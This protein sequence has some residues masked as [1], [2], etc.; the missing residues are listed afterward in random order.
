MISLHPL[1]LTARRLARHG[2]GAM[3]AVATLCL[4]GA[5]PMTGPRGVAAEPAPGDTLPLPVIALPEVVVTDSYERALATVRSATEGTVTRRQIE[6]RPLRRAG[7]LLESVPGFVVSQHS[8]EGKAN[9][10]YLRGFNLDH[11]TDV[12]ITLAGVPVNMPSHGHG[13]GYADLSYAIP[14][15]IAGIDYR[16]GTYTAADGDFSAAGAVQINYLNRL[17]RPIVRVTGGELG[18]GRLLAAASLDPARDQ[19]LLAAFDLFRNDGPWERPDDF[20]KGVGL[21][22]Y[23][24]GNAAAGFS[25]TAMGYDGRWNSTDQIPRRAVA[26]G[27]LDRY[28]AVDDTDGGRSHR[29]SLSGEYRNVTPAGITRSSAFLIHY[30]MRLWSNF[31]YFLGDPVNGDQFEQ[32]DDR[33]V[34]GG[35]VSRMRVGRMLARPVHHT[36]GLQVR[37][38]NIHGVGL[39]RT[40]ARERLATVRQ[41]DVRQTSVSPFAQSEIRWGETFRTVT[42]L[43]YDRYW[44]NVDSHLPVNS[45]NRGAGRL[46]PKLS[47]LFGPFRGAEYFVNMGYGFHSND[48]RGSTITRD[49]VTGDAVSPVTPLAA[50]FGAEVGFVGRVGPDVRLNAALWGLDIDSELLFIGDAGTT[51]ASRPSRRLG[52]ELTGTWTTARHLTTDASFAWSRARFRDEDPA[53]SR[54]PGAVE[55][56]ASAGVS[57]QPPA[58][59]YGEGRVRWFG[60]RPLMEDNS[61]RSESATMASLQAGYRF[62]PGLALEADV[63]NIFNARTSDVDYFYTSRLPGEPEAGVDDI[64]THPNEPRSVRLTISTSLGR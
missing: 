19:T 30:N 23:S 10:Y 20:R 15:L 33:M 35:R 32:S 40:R 22:R 4:T 3:T 58:G 26:S 8:G 61:V 21:L 9:Q 62:G 27:L 34:L 49:P 63:F 56:V 29:Y 60:P 47:L 44:F 17:E 39:Y 24:R 55:G 2:R 37:H 50:A 52:G 5:V 18:Y 28:G 45:G 53:G 38:D 14:E 48:A 42:G 59:W 11:G 16:K 36:L 12:A 54:I 13:Q 31:E 43:R 51:E 57:W 6:S 25:V 7:E 46:S 1:A 64:H 41:D